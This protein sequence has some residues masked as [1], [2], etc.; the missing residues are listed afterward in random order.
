MIQAIQS[1]SGYHTNS[2]SAATAAFAA[3]VAA[4]NL[5]VVGVSV[6]NNTSLTATVTDNLGNT[7]TQIGSFFGGGQPMIALF[8]AKNVLGGA[9]T[10]TVTPSASAFTGFS[11]TEYSGAD[12]SSPLDGTST[13]S[14]SSSNTLSTGSVSV[15]AAG[16]LVCGLFG[17]GSGQTYIGT[18]GAMRTIRITD[19]IHLNFA[20]LNSDASAP[21]TITNDQAVTYSAVGASFKAASG[22]GGSAVIVG[23]DD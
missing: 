2:T 8:Y 16:G 12:T 21:V 14:G 23:E 10:I 15:S 6:Y 19:G 18:T 9:C 17:H 20:D 7:Y 22:G 1:C 13:N 4:G 5:I 3:N 11:A